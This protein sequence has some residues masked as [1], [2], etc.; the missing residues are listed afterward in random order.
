MGYVWRA[1]SNTVVLYS[2]SCYNCFY[3]QYQA[4][5]VTARG[6]ARGKAFWPWR[7]VPSFR[8]EATMKTITPCDTPTKWPFPP[9]PARGK[10]PPRPTRGAMAVDIC[11]VVVWAALI[12]GLMWLGAASGF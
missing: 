9:A 12:P 8:H 4:L 11:L 10:A 2:S 1:G 3:E 7:A 6:Q 5:G